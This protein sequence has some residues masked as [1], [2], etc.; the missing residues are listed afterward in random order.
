MIYLYCSALPK[1]FSAEKAAISLKK[2][3]S[4][5]ENAEYIDKIANRIPSA[6]AEGL[7]A[8]DILSKMIEE[9]FPDTDLENIILSRGE[10][11]KPYFKNSRL[12]FNL[13]HS[14]GIVAC[15]LSDGGEVGVDVE[16]TEI[17]PQKARKLAERFF[18]ENEKAEVSRRPESFARIWTKKEA[19]AKC[20]G[21]NLADFEKNLPEI[22]EFTKISFHNFKYRKH[23]V[24]LCTIRDF[25]KIILLGDVKK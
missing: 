23:P 9:H 2:R 1:G 7:Y 21:A 19:L 22:N 15:A 20:F 17:P 11:G 24:T 5:N 3:F 12:D 18:D 10:N 6:A 14:G 4:G 25:S 16:T 8:L 13:S